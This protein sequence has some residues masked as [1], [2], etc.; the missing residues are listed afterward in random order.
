MNSSFELVESRTDIFKDLLI[1][2]IDLNSLSIDLPSHILFL[3]NSICFYQIFLDTELWCVTLICIFIEKHS[4]TILNRC[5]SYFH[6]T[7]PTKRH[8][9]YTS[10]H[11]LS[12]KSTTY[13]KGKTRIVYMLLQVISRPSLMFKRNYFSE[14]S[15][16]HS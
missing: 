7:L 6:K 8:I 9:F 13:S 12:L 3:T 11:I 10:E 1:E 16:S 14:K 2:E 5:S 4:L 15:Y